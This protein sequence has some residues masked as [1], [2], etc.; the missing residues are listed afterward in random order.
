MVSSPFKATPHIAL[1][2]NGNGVLASDA[3]NGGVTI[4]ELSDHFGPR[5]LLLWGGITTLN[6]TRGVALN[7]GVATFEPSG[8]FAPSGSVSSCSGLAN[9][10][11][12]R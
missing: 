7:G 3:L 4:F 12:G 5:T 6:A 11:W 2:R 8:R 10:G 1:Q 9:G